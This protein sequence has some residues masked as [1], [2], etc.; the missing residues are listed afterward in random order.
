MLQR[1]REALF[2]AL[3]GVRG[4]SRLVFPP[5]PLP[6]IQRNKYSKAMSHAILTPTSPFPSLLVS[7]GHILD[8]MG[9]SVRHIS[10]LDTKGKT[11]SFTELLPEEALYLADR[12]SLQIWFGS[13]PQTVE[14]Y[15]AGMGEWRDEGCG[16]HG[17][18]EMSVMEAFGV[19]IGR[20]GLTWERYQ[21]R[22]N[23]DYKQLVTLVGVRIP[24][25]SR[26][27]RSA[28]QALYT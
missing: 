14:E 8:S 26:L 27:H 15:A 12:G 23:E 22:A 24:Q 18:V 20:E 3:V 6:V 2:N 11:R 28:R 16:V 4:G 13:D 25:T 10:R 9:I 7:R 5:R 17:A 21:V 1:S 19:F